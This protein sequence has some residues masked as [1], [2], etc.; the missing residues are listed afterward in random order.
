MLSSSFFTLLLALTAASSPVVIRDN[1]IKLPLVKRINSTGSA[2]ILQRDQARAKSFKTQGRPHSTQFKHGSTA[3]AAPVSVPITNGVVSYTV[4]VSIGSPAK[5]FNL[6]V[7]TGSSNTWAGAD[8]SN[9]VPAGSR[10]TGQLVEVIYGSGAFLGEEVIDTIT[11][12]G[13]TIPSQSIGDAV[14]SEGFEGVDGILGIG[15]TDLTEDT[16]SGGGTV[17]TVTDNAFTL[18]L[19][20][21]KEVGISLEPTTSLSVTNGELVFGGIDTSKFT[22]NLLSVPI[23]STS[24][25]S[26]FVGIDQTITYGTAGT[27]ILAS[28]AGILDTGTTLLLI[29]SDAIAAYEAATGAVLDETTGLLTITSAQFANLQSLFFQIGGE[30]FEFTPNAQL[31]P[32]ALNTAIGGQADSIYLIV[33]D[34]GTESGEGLD[35]I[36]GQSFLER[37]Y[38][39]FDSGN[40]QVGLATT[41]FTDATTN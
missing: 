7:D 29:A 26:T 36:N 5:T 1:L 15:P 4:E 31:F 24:P 8:E 14:I 30:T 2:N 3:A 19:I 34:L 28:T 25:A 6:I 23:T 11:L 41:P 16:T 39:V 35:F 12:G 20:G 40:S 22:G 27:P 38:L 32:R 37:F 21:T 13:L 33:G 9:P 18:G 10:S 17:P